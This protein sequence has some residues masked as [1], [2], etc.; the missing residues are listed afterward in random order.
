[1]PQH[2]PPFNDF[3]I[4]IHRFIAADD[5]I[6]DSVLTYRDDRLGA[7]V[8][9]WTDAVAPSGGLPLGT[10]QAFLFP[11]GTV[12]L[13]YRELYGADTALGATGVVGVTLVLSRIPPCNACLRSTLHVMPY[14]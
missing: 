1:M 2:L 14:S 13:A 6:P 7:F 12:G 8:V 11:N 10:F 9:Q 5:I 3:K 4:M